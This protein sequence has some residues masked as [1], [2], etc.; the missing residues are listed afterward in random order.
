MISDQKLLLRRVELLFG[1]GFSMSGK[2]GSVERT[3]DDRE[4]KYRRQY[5][6]LLRSIA[7]G[8]D[9][10]EDDL[11]EVL[12]AVGKSIDSVRQD[13]ATLRKRLKAAA[14]LAGNDDEIVE[15]VKRRDEMF[16]KKTALTEQADELRKV[17]ERWQETEA[18]RAL[19]ENNWRFACMN[20][21]TMKSEAEKL[22][23]STADPTA[24]TDE[25]LDPFQLELWGR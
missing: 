12:S 23:K 14:V 6:E 24:S 7:E 25:Q 17:A 9:P 16:D 19:W 4:A 2:L 13:A 20:V 3:L 8:G 1:K 15:A 22:L 10:D 21:G 11:G 5:V 18:Q